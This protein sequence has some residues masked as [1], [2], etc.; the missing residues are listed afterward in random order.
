MEG[1]HFVAH[2]ASHPGCRPRSLMMTVIISIPYSP[3]C[4][5]GIGELEGRLVP[6]EPQRL[7]ESRGDSLACRDQEGEWRLR[8]GPQVPRLKGLE[9]RA[10]WQPHFTDAQTEAQRGR[11]TVPV[12][13][14]K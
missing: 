7:G 1:A 12:A 14:N 2:T 3:C 13:Q 10:V 5:G 4:R 6:E 8:A 11:E 9:G